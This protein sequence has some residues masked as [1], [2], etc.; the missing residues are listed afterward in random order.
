MLPC[1]WLGKVKKHFSEMD[2]KQLAVA[3]NAIDVLGYFLYRLIGCTD[4]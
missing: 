1:G 2:P 4:A 3:Q